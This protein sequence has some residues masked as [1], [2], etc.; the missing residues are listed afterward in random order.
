MHATILCHMFQLVENGGVV[1]PLFSAA[2][3]TDPLMTNQLFVHQYLQQLLKQAF[4]H[5]Q[6]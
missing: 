1:T 4:P 3:V 5:L 2:Q 6:E